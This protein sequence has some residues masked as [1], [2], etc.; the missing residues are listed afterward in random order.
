MDNASM[1]AATELCERRLGELLDRRGE[2]MVQQCLDE[3]IQRTEVSMREALD[4][5]GERGRGRKD[6]QRRKRD[7]KRTGRR[8]GNGRCST[9]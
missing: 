9:T 6:Q 1:I 3:M 2:G 5:L 7:A 8:T 4:V